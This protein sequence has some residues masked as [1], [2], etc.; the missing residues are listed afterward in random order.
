MYK[1]NVEENTRNIIEKENGLVGNIVRII[2]LYCTLF[3][4]KISICITSS[5]S[6]AVVLLKNLIFI[7]FLAF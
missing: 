2:Q 3:H 6:T 4:Q 5:F 7:T 1:N